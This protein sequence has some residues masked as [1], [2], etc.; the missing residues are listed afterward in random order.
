MQ[1]RTLGL[2]KQNVTMKPAG[3]SKLRDKAEEIL[4]DRLAEWLE[5]CE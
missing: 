4:G 5:E 3:G 2:L 1:L